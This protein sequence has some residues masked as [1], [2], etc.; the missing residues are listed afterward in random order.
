MMDFRRIERLLGRLCLVALAGLIGVVVWTAQPWNRETLALRPDTGARAGALDDAGAAA[1]LG[2]LLTRVYTAF[3]ETEEGA[4]YD[5]LATAVSDD[6][7][8]DLYLQRRAIQIREA[9][10][11]GKTEIVDLQL[12]V[13]DVLSRTGQQIVVATEWTVI[14]LVGHAD[15]RHERING[16]AATLTLGPADG[17]WRLTRFDLDQIERQDVPLFFGSF[18]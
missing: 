11:P 13:A 1:V 2:T 15:H 9:E 16:Y 12:D 4:I 17:A 14:G 18:E 6:L 8:P 5:G 10:E 3:G 7:L